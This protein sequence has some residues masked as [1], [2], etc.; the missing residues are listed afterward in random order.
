LPQKNALRNESRSDEKPS[1]QLGQAAEFF[2]ARQPNVIFGHSHLADGLSTELENG[3]GPHGY[4]RIKART[5][6]MQQ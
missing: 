1:R 2:P 3:N 4:F 6:D 5:S